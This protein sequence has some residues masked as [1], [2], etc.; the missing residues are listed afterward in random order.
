[1]LSRLLTRHKQAVAPTKSIKSRTWWHGTTR[2]AA[3]KIIHEGFKAREIELANDQGYL[4][5]QE[6]RI[7]FADSIKQAFSY[8]ALRT[9]AIGASGN[10][11]IFQIPGSAFNDITLDED[12]LADIIIAYAGKDNH[13]D[14]HLDSTAAMNISIYAKNNPSVCKAVFEMMKKNLPRFKEMVDSSNY[15]FDELVPLCKAAIQKKIV[16]D[17][18]TLKIIDELPAAIT[19]DGVI[20]P[21]KLYIVP[22]DGYSQI[23]NNF[24]VNDSFVQDLWEHAKSHMKVIEVNHGR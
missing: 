10:L 23:E 14:D 22:L 12:T 2:E 11:Y 8:S 19:S 9:G 6:G 20:W 21:D 4:A 1:M 18:L 13:T 17:F 24:E 5:P 3:N 7:Y 15:N 16:P